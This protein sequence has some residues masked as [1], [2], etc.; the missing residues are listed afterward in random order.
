MSVT[1]RQGIITCIPKE[2]KD[3]QFLKNWRPITPLNS[4]YKIASSCITE[5][6]KTVLHKLIGEDQKGFL[7]GRYIG[8]NI[9]LV[10]DTLMYT[11]KHQIPGLLL[12]VDFE[13]AFDS[14]AWSFIEKPLSAFNFG[15]DIKR[16]VSTF[17]ANIKS[18]ISVNGNYSEWFD[19]KR[20]TRQGDLLSPYL[21][22]ICSEI[23]SLMIQ[24]NENIHGI[25]VL[26]EEI[27][28]TQFEDHTTFFLEGRQES[29]CAC[30]HTLQLFAQI[31]GLKTNCEKNNGGVDRITK[32]FTC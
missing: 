8:E 6:L 15:N 22:L 4:E 13:K 30:I 28:L 25:K 10:Y 14:V 21:F 26:D 12:M 17:Y 2:G 31:S 32:T 5:R 19:V 1:Q 9:R 18:C 16:W 11:G 3:K 7:K 24:Q 29:F 20:G 27:L 23:L